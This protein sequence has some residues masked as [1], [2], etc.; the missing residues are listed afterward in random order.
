MGGERRGGKGAWVGRGEEGRRHGWGGEKREGDMGGEG[1]GGK[2]TWVGRG[3]E[4]RGG[5]GAWV[6]RG[7]EGGSGGDM[8]GGV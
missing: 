3:E 2:G 5:K 4:G 6:G 1:R 7:E 8:G